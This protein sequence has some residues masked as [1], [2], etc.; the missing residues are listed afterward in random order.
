ML[1]ELLFHMV[2]TA[3]LG[4]NDKW[5][6]STLCHLTAKEVDEQSSQGMASKDGESD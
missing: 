3:K 4:R 1:Q 6:K 5:E 2:L